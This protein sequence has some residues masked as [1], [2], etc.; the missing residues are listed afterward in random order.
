MKKFLSSLIFIIIII[1]IYIYRNNITDFVLNTSNMVTK[2]EIVIPKVNEYK[3]ENSNYSYVSNTENFI[4]K[5]KQD[6]LNIIYT[7]LNSGWDEF[8]FYCPNEYKSCVD[9]V[10]EITNNN[11]IL[12]NINGFVHP[13]NS[14]K[15]IE[16]AYTTQGKIT[17]N[18][19]KI[20]TEDMINEINNVVDKVIIEKLSST[21][22]DEEKIR[23]IHDYIIN[24]SKYDNER[25]MGITKYN[26]NIAY[27]NLIQGYG[28]CSGYTDSMAIFLNKLGI[29]N[30]KI[31]SDKHIWN[32]VY[33]NDKWLNLD[34]T[35]DDPVANTGEDILQHDYFLIDTNKLLELDK[36]EHTFDDK[37]FVEAK[38]AD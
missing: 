12:S 5:T 37:V 17:L 24:N 20:Y 11:L 34:L 8:T 9:D 38:N 27:G 28:I 2:K 3:K 33:I 7:T 21:I 19:H 10:V 6:I 31:S 15:S 29:Q 36:D 23:I 18:V 35:F 26:S 16:T 14:F 25:I 32:L 30:Y 13:Y 1:T 22:S 4:P